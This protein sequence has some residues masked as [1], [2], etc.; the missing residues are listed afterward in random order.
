MKVSGVDE[1]QETLAGALFSLKS[2]RITDVVD[3]ISQSVALLP[4]E[5]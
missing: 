3:A 2:D 5:R 4:A 1:G